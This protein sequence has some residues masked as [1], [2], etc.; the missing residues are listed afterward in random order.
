M[1]ALLCGYCAGREQ[2]SSHDMYKLVQD[3][4]R[5]MKWAILL[6]MDV[7]WVPVALLIAFVLHT[8][9]LGVMNF[10]LVNKF[11]AIALMG[12]SALLSIITNTYRIQLKS[13]ERRAVGLT[14]IH[15]FALGGFAFVLDRLAEYGSAW[16]VFV[17]FMLSYFLLAVSARV[18][19]LQVLLAIHRLKTEQ[20][21]VMVYG[22]GATGRQLVAALRT[23]DRIHPVGYIDDDR[24][25]QGSMVQ[26][27]RVHSPSE[28]Q[29]LVIRK[30]ADRILLAMPSMPRAELIKLSQELENNGFIVQS[31]PSF[32]QLAQTG[33]VVET[34]QPVVPGRFIGRSTLDKEISVSISSYAGKSLLVTGAGGS[35]GSELCR[36]IIMNK[37]KKLV[38]YELSEPALY[39]IYEE[40]K[41]L[42][43]EDRVTTVP[44][45]GTVTDK[46]LVRKVVM[47]HGIETIVHAAAYKHVPIVERNVFSGVTN[48]VFGTKTLAEAAIDCNVESFI[49]V[50]SDKAVRPSSMMGATKRIAE[51]V[52]KDSSETAV[53]G[54]LNTTFTMVRFGNVIGSSGSV[55]PLFQDQIRRGGPITLTHPD[56]TR[57]FMTVPEAAQLVLQAG[58]SGKNGE[59]FV[60]DMGEPMR[61]E[62]LATRLTKAAGLTV[63]NEDCPD[64][65]IEFHYIGLR[66]GEKLHEELTMGRKQRSTIHPKIFEAYETWPSSDRIE[67]MLFDLKSAVENLDEAQLKV[68]L[69]KS[70][71]PVVSTAEQGIGNGD[72][73]NA[74]DNQSV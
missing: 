48:N 45:L 72:A 62:E 39:A 3:M 31:L 40:L 30:K 36:Q 29:R 69:L 35:I 63:R 12:I 49:F 68:V 66:D 26:G 1:K 67:Q 55:V 23:D 2:G 41:T 46:N 74:I 11:A 54:N 57:F 9:T 71:L 47:E 10:P 44:V 22:A 51:L 7:F 58:T 73:F 59:L 6:L 4:P 38:L 14:A 16:S 5:A 37:P 17:I 24:A 15:T 65:D 19:L 13:Y 32:G 34:L 21:R 18:I 27:L 25:L 43:D 64:G 53:N 33:N 8:S 42:Q 28:I 52:I 61:I 56:V 50:S 60:L 20:T 70:S